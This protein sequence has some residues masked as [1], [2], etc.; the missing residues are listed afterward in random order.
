MKEL[1]KLLELG[2]S[3]ALQPKYKKRG[4][5]V[6]VV[7]PVGVFEVTGESTEECLKLLLKEVQE[8]GDYN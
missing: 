3:V 8:N 6:S 7:G 4:I 2:Y 5:W 1:D